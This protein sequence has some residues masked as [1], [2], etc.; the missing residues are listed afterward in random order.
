MELPPFERYRQNYLTDEEFRAFQ[1]MLLKDPVAGDVIQHT[2]GLRKVRFIDS[3]RKKGKRSGIRVIYYWWVSE[4][5]F[6]LFTIYNKDEMS[7]L[8]KEQRE[9]L[10]QMLE[11]RKKGT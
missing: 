8:T 11:M 3:R 10:R 1:N 4:L 2:G 5:Q 7:D 9:S 6:I